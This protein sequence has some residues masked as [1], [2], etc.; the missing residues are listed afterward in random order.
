MPGAADALAFAFER[1]VAPDD[2]D[3]TVLRAAIA[4]CAVAAA[5][6]ERL[7]ERD[8]ATIN[9][10]AGD[11][12]PVPVL[13]ADRTRVLAAVDPPRAALAAL[14]RDAIETL[15]GD[16]RL[17]VCESP[18]CGAVFADRSRGRRRRWCSM[19]RCGNQIKVAA[20]RRRRRAERA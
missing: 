11:E 12:T 18:G 4:R 2:D 6:R 8:V 1:P 20:F 15:A 10:F 9:S 16:A 17:H 5:R 14:A 7:P 19:A 3:L 13:R